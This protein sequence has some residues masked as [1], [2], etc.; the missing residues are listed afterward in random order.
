MYSPSATSLGAVMAGALWRAVELEAARE[1]ASSAERVRAL[2]LMAV[3][4]LSPKS[5]SFFITYKYI[6]CIDFE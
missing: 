1:R 6:M 5:N 2:M 4:A 3:A